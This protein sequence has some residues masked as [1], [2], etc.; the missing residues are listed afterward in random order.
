[1][2]VEKIGQ[3]IASKRYPARRIAAMTTAPG[4]AADAV[5]GAV[6]GASDMRGSFGAVSFILADVRCG[7]KGRG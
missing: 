2:I 7:R 4:S 5:S 6:E 1:V 3:L